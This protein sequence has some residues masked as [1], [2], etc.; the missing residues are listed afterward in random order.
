MLDLI[1]GL[2]LL[3]ALIRGYR[4]GFLRG[5]IELGGFVVAVL[6]GYRAGPA[7]GVV[8]ESWS[9]A[10]PLA[11]RVIGSVT[12]FAVILA[13]AMLVARRLVWVPAPLR[14]LDRIAGAVASGAWFT[15]LA[16]LLLILAGAVPVLP[17]RID[18]LLSGS[19]AAR[20]VISE[21]A[22][23]TPVVSRL[24]GD[25]VIE[26][27][28][29]INRLV[30]RSHVVIE[31]DDSVDLPVAGSRQLVERP[32]SARELFAKINLARIEEGVGAVAWSVALTDVAG[33]HGREMYEQGYFS[34]L[35]PK[36]GSLDDRLY[37]SGIPF[38][39]A[40]ENLAL[41][42][43]VSSVHEGLLSSASHRA[44]MLDPRFTRV[45]VSAVEGPLG[46]MVVQ[47]FTG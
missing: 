2:G 30:G 38:R 12:V 28:V 26:S 6:V 15:V 45:G 5:L 18:G 10:D 40:G 37:E 3:A 35:S 4:H 9:G 11:A 13:G 21:G 32:D 36:A 24:L 46:L 33:G 16:V 20:V 25:R 41:S 27:L 29:N 23:V 7:A 42:P 43:T 34:H 39:A 8:I 44:T 47:V 1:L 31:G 19:R 22:A 14:P 17:G